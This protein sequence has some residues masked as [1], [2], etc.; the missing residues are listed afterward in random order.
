MLKLKPAS[1]RSS[2]AFGEETGKV[3]LEGGR[4][5]TGN[6]GLKPPSQPGCAFIVTYMHVHFLSSSSVLGLWELCKL[7]IM[8]MYLPRCRSSHCLCFTGFSSRLE[9]KGGSKVQLLC[10]L[11]P[12]LPARLHGRV[13]HQSW[14]LPGTVV[15]QPAGTTRPLWCLGV[16]SQKV[17]SWNTNISLSFY[18]PAHECVHHGAGA[19]ILHIGWLDSLPGALAVALILKDK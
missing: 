10:V 11:H 1:W 5:G 16:L 15:L 17:M 14:H 7:K 9:V 3:S 8:R 12:P 19:F 13:W 6:R 2:V 18:F 4:K